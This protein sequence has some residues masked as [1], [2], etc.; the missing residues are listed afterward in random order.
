MCHP[1]Q[2][3]PSQI[4]HSD[5]FVSKLQGKRVFLKKKTI[6]QLE[7]M[8]RGELCWDSK[9]VD[10]R[11]QISNNIEVIMPHT[12]CIEWNSSSQAYI[13]LLIYSWGRWGEE[14][15]TVFK[16]TKIRRWWW[17]NKK[18]T[19]KGV[20][21]K[22]ATTKTF[23]KRMKYISGKNE[24]TQSFLDSKVKCSAEISS[25]FS[26]VSLRQRVLSN[27]SYP[28]SRKQRETA[29]DQL[30]SPLTFNLLAEV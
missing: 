27:L 28:H 14:A 17:L 19:K 21:L 20:S 7:W 5:Q 13:L 9:I 10:W 30:F 22:K 29:D 23:E 4:L 12:L 6:E 3:I 24:I 2:Y 11:L 1:C 26:Q 8:S 25:L 16:S 18:I 15:L